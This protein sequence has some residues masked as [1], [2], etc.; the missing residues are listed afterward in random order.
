MSAP[1]RLAVRS[2]LA[3]GTALLM[4]AGASFA[5]S[6]WSLGRA[7]LP[8]ALV[9]AFGKAALVL[10]FFMGL[11]R[12]RASVVYALAAAAVLLIIL[13]TLVLTDVLLRPVVAGP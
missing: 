9:I 2:A 8:V 11:R 12:E 5:L 10:L 1:D 3:V 4:L 13:L 6:R 7:A